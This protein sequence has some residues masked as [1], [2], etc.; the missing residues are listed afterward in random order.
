[1]LF[2]KQFK[3]SLNELLAFIKAVYSLIKRLYDHHLKGQY[4]VIKGRQ[5]PRTVLAVLCVFFLYLISPMSFLFNS[6]VREDSEIANTDSNAYEKDG[7][8][9]YEL[10]KCDMA[11][12]GILEYRGEQDIEKLR[13][14]LIFYNPAGQPVYEGNAETFQLVP[15][16]RMEFSIPCTEDF[17]YFKLKGVYINPPDETPTE[18]DE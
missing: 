2:K 12:C 7:L 8:K 9:V 1:M 6:S 15:N 3:A 5:I 10:R 13:I 4:V 11:A 17:G 18:F 16:S 14:T